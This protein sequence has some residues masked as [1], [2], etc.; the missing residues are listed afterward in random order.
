MGV[1]LVNENILIF[2]NSVSEQAL[3]KNATIHQVTIILFLGYNHLL[4][5]GADGA[6][7]I[8]KMKG[9]QHR[10]LAGVH[11]LEIGHF[12]RWIAWLIVAFLSSARPHIIT[13]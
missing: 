2:C 6:R 12:W 4:T 1:F 11:D 9:H 7:V 10:W 13:L 3:G 8:I 5:T